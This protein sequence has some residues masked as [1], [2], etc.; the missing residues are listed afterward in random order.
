LEIGHQTSGSTHENGR[1]KNFLKRNNWPIT[2]A[3]ENSSI[4]APKSNKFSFRSSFKISTIEHINASAIR[5][6]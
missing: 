2:N 6:N 5:F 4:E 3:C 1:I